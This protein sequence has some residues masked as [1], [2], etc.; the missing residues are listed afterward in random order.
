MAQTSIITGQYVCIRQPAATVMQR[1][2]AFLIDSAIIWFA[3]LSIAAIMSP[4]FSSEPAIAFYL[5]LQMALLMYPLGMEVFNN[6]QSVGKMAVG[7]KVAKLDGSKP[8]IGS[9]LLRWLLLLVDLLMGVVGLTFIIFTK[10]SQRL[11]DL[12]AGTTVVKVNRQNP[13]ISFY[14]LYYTNPNYQPTYPEAANLSMRQ[15]N[16]IARTLYSTNNKMREIDINML[17]NKVKDFLSVNPKEGTAEGFLTTIFNDFQ[18][19]TTKVV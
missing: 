9:Y 5:I 15:F 18:Y 6:G 19:Y 4:F 8:S 12:A 10:N 7:I 13:S 17:G 2:V 14:D 3:S 16:L 1:F 11:G